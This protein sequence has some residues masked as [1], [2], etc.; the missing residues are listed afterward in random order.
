MNPEQDHTVPPARALPRRLRRLAPAAGLLAVAMAVSSGASFVSH[1]EASWR[2]GLQSIAQFSTPTVSPVLSIQCGAAESLGEELREG[3]EIGGAPIEESLE[4]YPLSEGAL[5]VEWQGDPD[6][7]HNEYSVL[8]DH[9]GAT[10]TTG[11][12]DADASGSSVTLPGSTSEIFSLATISVESSY[13][14]HWGEYPETPL[15]LSVATVELEGGEDLTVYSCEGT[16]VGETLST[17][18]DEEPEEEEEPEDE[19]A[20]EGSELED[21]DTEDAESP[22]TPSDETE[23]DLPENS[24]GTAEETPTAAPSPSEPEE[25]PSPTPDETPEPSEG[26]AEETPSPDNTTQSSEEVS[27]ED[28]D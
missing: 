11:P 18:P 20:E 3:L 9:A 2:S 10:E 17:A 6:S 24:D 7:Q 4:L 23:N 14:G 27:D 12:F 19:S 13:S 5:P 26:P 22:E 15:S 28:L 25:S 16:L 1:T 21:G 8:A